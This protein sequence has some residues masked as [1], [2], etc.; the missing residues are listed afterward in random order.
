MSGYQRSTQ[1][2]GKQVTLAGNT[3]AK[4]LTLLLAIDPNIPANVRELSIQMDGGQAG[5][6]LIGDSDI[7]TTVYG[8]ALVSTSGVPSVA[9]YMGSGSDICNV[10]LGSIYLLSSVAAKVNVFGFA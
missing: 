9:F 3:V 2:F 1:M 4:L 8:V 6:L 10:P 5:T 7:S